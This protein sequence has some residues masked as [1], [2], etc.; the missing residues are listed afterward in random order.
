MVKI[1]GRDR[2]NLNEFQTGVTGYMLG[3]V[4][5]RGSSEVSEHMAGIVYK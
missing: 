5:W 2:Q 3:G 1:I 4:I